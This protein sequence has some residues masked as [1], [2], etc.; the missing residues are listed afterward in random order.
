MAKEKRCFV[1]SGWQDWICCIRSFGPFK[2]RTCWRQR[3]CRFRMEIEPPFCFCH[4]DKKTSAVSLHWKSLNTPL[5]WAPRCSANNHHHLQHD[6]HEYEHLNF[7][8]VVLSLEACNRGNVC[9]RGNGQIMRSLPSF[10]WSRCSFEPASP[11]YPC[12]ASSL[13]SRSPEGSCLCQQLPLCR[14]GGGDVTT[15]VRRTLS[16]VR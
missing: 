12:L 13:S 8:C 5:L 1:W 14:S 4:R 16:Y 9:N 7:I 2:L 3:K 10:Y 6:Q 15:D 11:T